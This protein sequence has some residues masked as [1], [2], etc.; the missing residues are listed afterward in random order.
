MAKP[1]TLLGTQLFIKVG[2]EASPEVFTHPCLINSTRGVDFTVNGNKIEV[3]DCTNPDDPAWM[4]FVKQSIE[5]A[6]SG[7]GV[8]DNVEAT[9][10]TYFTWLSGSASK[11]VQVWVGTIGYWSGAF[12]L[13]KFSVSGDR[14]KKID[15]AI[16]LDS[17]GVITWTTGP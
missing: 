8:M 4:E 3:P 11:N 10:A 2:D 17:D 5:C 1:A 13:T 9:I 14:G 15:V 7:A 16:S 6:I 12:H